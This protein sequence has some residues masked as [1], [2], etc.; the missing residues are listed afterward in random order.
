VLYEMDV[1]TLHDARMDS[2]FV[3]GGY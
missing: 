1:D 2:A 3:Y